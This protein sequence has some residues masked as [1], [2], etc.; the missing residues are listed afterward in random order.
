MENK[1]NGERKLKIKQNWKQKE[2]KTKI[3]KTKNF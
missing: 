2:Y 1:K 3:L